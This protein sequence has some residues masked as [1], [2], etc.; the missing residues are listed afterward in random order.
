MKHLMRKTVDLRL[1]SGS[2]NRT[3]RQL[4]AQAGRSDI[5]LFLIKLARDAMQR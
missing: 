4:L 2:V 1:S 3:Y 5:N